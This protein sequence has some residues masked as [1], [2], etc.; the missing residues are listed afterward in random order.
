MYIIYE[1]DADV[2]KHSSDG[3][4]K[5]QP[6]PPPLNFPSLFIIEKLGLLTHVVGNLSH[7]GIARRALPASGG[8][9]AVGEIKMLIKVN[10]THTVSM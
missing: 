4:L 9:D 5:S 2:P 1:R 10:D 3:G 7:K 6:T 8:K